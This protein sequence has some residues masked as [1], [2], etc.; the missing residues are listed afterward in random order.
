MAKYICFVKLESDYATVQEKIGQTRF[1]KVN[2]LKDLYQ[3][4]IEQCD[5]GNQ[6]KVH[7]LWV[8]TFR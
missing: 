4:G 3:L 6:S 7:I 5:R 2:A 1:L 8:Q